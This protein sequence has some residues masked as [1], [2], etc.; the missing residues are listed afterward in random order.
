MTEEEKK[1]LYEKVLEKANRPGTFTTVNG[2][3]ITSVCD[4]ASEGECV[5]EARHKNPNGLPHG[6]VYCTMLDQVAGTA[7][8]SRGGLCRTVSCEVRFYAPASGERLYS[9]ARALRMGH[10]IAVI[11]AWLTDEGGTTCAEG[12][13]TYRMK[14]EA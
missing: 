2:L 6:G 4:G 13:Y 3:Q 7:A 5:L 10:T 11:H 1:E 9:H 12:T 8:C 14:T